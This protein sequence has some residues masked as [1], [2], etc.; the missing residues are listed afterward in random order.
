[1][2]FAIFIDGVEKEIDV[3]KKGDSYLF[4]IEGRRYQVSAQPLANGALTFFVGSRSYVAHISNGEGGKHL[5]I[6]GRNFFIEGDRED[7]NRRA[8]AGASAQADG[9]VES[10]MPGNIIAVNVKVG[11]VVE[12]DQAVVVI[13]SMK[14]Q[15]EITAPVA[16]V[17]EKV[18]C[19]VGEQVNFGKV[20]VEIKPKE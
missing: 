11:D 9:K 8:G 18:N 3:E 7:G 5:A 1:V 6:G 4:T 20:L 16:G 12:A 19:S 14:M 2:G 10:P 13:E 17:V 15:N